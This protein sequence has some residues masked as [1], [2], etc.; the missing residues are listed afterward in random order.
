MVYGIGSNTELDYINN[1]I[2]QVTV[3]HYLKLP[4]GTK[5][6][7][8]VAEDE[9]KQGPIDEDYTALPKKDL[10]KL[11][12]EKVDGEYVLPSNMTGKIKEEPQEVI[13]YY[14]PSEI[15]LTINHYYEG[16]TTRIEQ[17]EPEEITYPATVVDNGDGTYTITAEGSYDID[18]NENYNT[19]INKYKF[20]RVTSNVNDD[21]NLED[22]L[23]FNKNSEINFYYTE[24]GYKITTEVIPHTEKRT[25]EFTNQKVEV[26]VDG[27]IISGN[28]NAEYKEENR[29]KFVETVKENKNQSVKTIIIATP[30]E[31]YRVK[32]IQ[33]IS[34]TSDGQTEERTLYGE[35]IDENVEVKATENADGSVTLSTFK[36]V[37]ADKHIKVEFEPILSKVIVHHYYEG[38]GEEF[39][40]DPIAVKNVD[41]EDIPNEEME[42]Y[43]NEKYFTKPSSEYAEYYKYVSS[44]QRT[45]GKYAPDVIHVYYYYKYNDY[46]YRIEHYYE[47]KETGGYEIDDSLTDIKAGKFADVV[48]IS[49]A[50]KKLKPE[51]GYKKQE[52]AP[53]TITVDSEDNV[54]RLYYGLQYEITTDVIEHNEQYKETIDEDGNVITN[55]VTGI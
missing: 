55:V 22:T 5:T 16:T 47:N 4:D 27:G 21:T 45:V 28:Y 17:T 3:H 31:Y 52:G 32:T 53:L 54:I 35:N 10:E 7:Y 8:K 38:T 13:F 39:G 12:L 2:S 18:T 42:D 36:N 30:D 37:T 29:I 33:L 49:D 25:D 6:E 34:T 23:T 40:N 15:K 24:K 1:K 9:L 19:I 50:D 14:E 43:I 26:S 11:D 41:G 44:S 46:T 51:Y 20:T 48:D